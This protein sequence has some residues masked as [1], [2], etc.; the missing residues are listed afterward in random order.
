MEGHRFDLLTTLISRRH[1]G[2]VLI[3][4]GLGAGL[5]AAVETDAR[6]KKKKCKKGTVKCG[7]ACVNTQ[8]SP[9][10]CGGCGATCSSSQ[11]CV[12]G[13]CAQTECEADEI[14]CSGGRVQSGRAIHRV[15]RRGRLRRSAVFR[16]DVQPD[17]P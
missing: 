12:D 8:T 1:L 3:I 13:S 15:L 6:K 10:H 14:P 11:S 7:K 5:G 17:D 4:L 9:S 16:S 2:R